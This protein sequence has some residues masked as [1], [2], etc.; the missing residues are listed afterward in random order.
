MAKPLCALT[1]GDPA[2]IGPEVVLKTIFSERARDAADMVVI[3]FPGPF[4]RDAAMLG[5]DVE[6]QVLDSPEKAVS[7]EGVLPLVVPGGSTGWVPEYG[8]EDGWCGKTAGT[9]IEK[10]AELA[11]SGAVDA[12][13]TAPINKKSLSLAGYDYPGHTEFYRDLTGAREIAMMLT[14]G[15]L[16]VVHTTTHVAIKDVPALIKRG[17]IVRV[18][19]LMHEALL[20]LG[21][22][23]PRIAVAGLNPHAGEGG[24][25]G[26]EELEEIIPA[27]EELRAGGMD[28]EGPLPPDTVFSRAYGGEFDGVAAMYHDQGHI[29]LKLAGFRFGGDRRDVAGVNVTLGLPIIRTSADHGTAFDIAGK[30]VASPSSMVEAVE[31]AAA[32]VKGKRRLGSRGGETSG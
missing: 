15:T 6:I 22:E 13:V 23:S 14:L 28:V 12:V 2:G 11:L 20:L 26:R 4:R 25:F 24:L 1:M 17:R 32:L 30:G 29:A 3:G 18:A 31:M 7:E 27:V 8:S 21:I 5:I 19:S 16:R 9:C 10:S